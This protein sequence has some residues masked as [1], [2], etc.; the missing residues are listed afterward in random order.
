MTMNKIDLD[1]KGI[2]F[3]IRAMIWVTD[4]GD[5]INRQFDLNNRP[6]Y[7]PPQTLPEGIRRDIDLTSLITEVVV[8][9]F[10]HASRLAEEQSLLTAAGIAA[11]VRESSLTRYSPFIPSDDELRRF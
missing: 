11:S 2:A 9:P 3:E 8:S 6:I 4:S 10:A 7:E 1:T 5:G